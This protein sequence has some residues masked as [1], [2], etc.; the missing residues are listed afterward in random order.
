MWLSKG[1][2]LGKFSNHR[3]VNDKLLLAIQ[4]FRFVF[5]PSNPR[6]QEIRHT[7]CLPQCQRWL[8]LSA[9][10]EPV[11]EQDLDLRSSFLTLGRADA[12]IALLSLNWNLLHKLS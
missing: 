5:M 8:T 11:Q 2:H 9:G 6:T 7:E 12:N 4:P 3:L 1:L 10:K